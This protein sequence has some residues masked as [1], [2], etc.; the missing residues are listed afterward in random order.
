MAAAHDVPS[1]VTYLF[2]GLLVA[3]IASLALEE[4]LHAKKSVIVG[5]FAI[6]SLFLGSYFG[7]MP[8]GELTLADGHKLSMPVY[9]PAVDWSVIAIIVGSGFLWMLPR[10]R[11]C[12]H[13]LRLN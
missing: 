7:L 6:I 4:K 11:A 1:W 3:M 12:S 8:F 9:I 13:G 2:A 5:V 10:A